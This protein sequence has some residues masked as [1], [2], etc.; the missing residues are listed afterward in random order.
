M[1]TFSKETLREALNGLRVLKL[2]KQHMP[3]L[4]QV[5]VFGCEELVEFTGTNLDQYLRYEGTGASTQALRML[6]PSE[7][8][9]DV[10]KKADGGTDIQIQG[11]DVPLIRYRA[12]GVE[13]DEL[14]TPVALEE[15]PAIPVSDGDPIALPA[16]VLA[17]MSEALG[18]ASTDETRYILNSVYLDAHAVVATDGRQLY[19]RNSL[20]LAM[21]QGA[22]FPASLVPGILP[23][24]EVAHLWLWHREEHPFAQITVG[25][26]RWITKLVEGNFPNY[27]HVIP[28]VEN[29][30]GFVRI[31]EPD[32]V[33][34]QSVLPKLPGY[35]DKDSKVV[36]SITEKGAVIRTAANLPKVHVAL[37][38]SEVVS[39]PESEVAFNSRYLLGALQR[40]M[41]DL[42]TRDAVSPLM[43]TDSNRIH[44]WMPLRDVVPTP[45]PTASTVPVTPP[46]DP[47]GES[48]VQVVPSEPASQVSAV[49]E[50]NVSENQHINTTTTM[51]AS[52]NNQ[53]VI[54]TRESSSPVASAPRVVLAE[55]P[56]SAADAVQA[57][58][59]KVRDLLRDLGT[60]I[61]GLQ[62]LLREST[63]QYKAL[64]REHESLKKNIRALRE[65]PV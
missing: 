11:G 46:S 9:Q 18:C 29:Y 42:H 51:V 37:D 32:A 21:P 30:G 23:H 39:T 2:S 40:G 13:L 47:S 20:E 25:Y 28:K 19:R 36:L 12:S 53:P 38:R 55:T 57:K 26:W 63:R 24:N 27:Q 43:M 61:G 3:V 35:K 34:L 16:G 48:P 17:S 14:F 6:V 15:F 31:S 8:L 33:R 50:T 22:I 44:L 64:E 49:S 65:V 54:E 58:L 60:E 56:V 59:G 62:S 1:I 4:R 45:V 7:L 41:R 52:S 10:A 5:L